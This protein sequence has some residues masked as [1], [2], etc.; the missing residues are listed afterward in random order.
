MVSLHEIMH[1]AGATMWQWPK[2]SVMNI[3][4]YLFLML[5]AVLSSCGDKAARPAEPEEDA[6]AKQLLQGIWINE[7]DQD[8]AFRVKG[9][10]H[11]L[12]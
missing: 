5:V 2:W 9:R 8:V 11:F 6:K 10:H 1:T 12:S 3:K 7:D 4:L